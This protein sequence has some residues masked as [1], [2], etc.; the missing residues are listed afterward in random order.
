MLCIRGVIV[1]GELV[2]LPQSAIAIGLI[3]E[4]L[5]GQEM[6]IACDM[7]GIS[8]FGFGLGTEPALTAMLGVTTDC[9]GQLQDNNLHLFPELTNRP[10]VYVLGSCRGVYYVPEIVTD[11]GAAALAV[12]SLLSQKNLVVEPGNAMVD[13]DKCALCL[14]CIRSCPHGAMAVDPGK[15]AA[16]SL[17]EVCRRC[18]VCVGECPASAI[19][20]PGEKRQHSTE[21]ASPRKKIEHAAAGTTRR[22]NGRTR[23]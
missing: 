17:P 1:S 15:R 20:L 23:R 12:H 6:A 13:A 2:G 4:E 3:N 19:S 9:Q 14:T 7:V 10:G 18:G 22:G 16:M 21:T 8:P 5:L 11:A